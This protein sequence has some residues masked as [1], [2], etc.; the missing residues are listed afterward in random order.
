M[1]ANKPSDS[2]KRSG[3]KDEPGS[4]ASDIRLTIYEVLFFLLKEEDSGVIKLAVMRIVDFFQLMVFPFSGNADF[5]WKAGSVYNNFESII[6]TFQIVNYLSNFPWLTYLIVF[7]LGILLVLL[8]ILDI[9]YVMYSLTR[10][11]FAYLWPLKV[12]TSFCSIFVTVLFLP[13]LSTPIPSVS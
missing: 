1:D 7:Y 8:V 10:K 6:E 4:T 12:L 13:L 5:P 2:K 3:S 9:I 11:N